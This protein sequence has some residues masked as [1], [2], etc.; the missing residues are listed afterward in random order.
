M[1]G[2]GAGRERSGPL[3]DRFVAAAILLVLAGMLWLVFVHNVN[4]DEFYYLQQVHEH[5]NG[6]L[7]RPLQTFHVHFFQ[8]LTRLPF[9]EMGQ[10]IAVR[11]VMLALFAGT[12]ALIW[13]T[14]RAMVEARFAAIGALCFLGAG[15]AVGHGASF[16]ADPIVAF[17]LMVSLCILFALRLTPLR[18]ALAGLAGAL[19][20]MVSI[21]AVLFAPAFL[22]PVLWRRDEPGALVRVG[23]AGVSAAAFTVVLYLWHKAQLG[24]AGVAQTVEIAG[25]AWSRAILSGPL[26]PRGNEVLL[27]AL[28]SVGPVA[29]I[30]AAFAVRGRP[31]RQ[32]VTLLLLVLPFASVLFYR[33]AFPY[34]FPFIV[35]PLMVAAA[36]GARALGRRPAM[37]ARVL[38]LVAASAVLQ[39]GLSVREGNAVQYRLI[40]AVHK[41]FPEPVAY[42]D[43]NGMI[44]QFPKVGFFMSSWGIANYRRDGLPIFEDILREH[45]PP[46]LIANAP[47][48]DNALTGNGD[49]ASCCGLFLEDREVLRDNYL[50]HSGAVWL[51]GRVLEL[52]SSPRD[53]G[54]LIEGPYRIEAEGTVTINGILH[55]SGEVAQIRQGLNV[56][57]AEQ[58]TALRLLWATERDA[59]ELRALEGPIYYGF[60][61]L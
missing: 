11:L 2:H 43:R 37:L 48:L 24:D 42:I 56:M 25:S 46:L 52:D 47:A 14:A 38:F 21:K 27:W 59:G 33:N 54:F 35:P 45:R 31:L 40:A 3:L 32:T 5:A 36:V 22:A 15:F 29:F 26:L 58:G 60:W 30:L 23:L 1:A 9:D 34:F 4:W 50:H 61:R 41:L 8:W 13:R 18:L 10:V 44:S 20:F 12:A 17:L 49:D 55:A 39:F 6:T 19:A 28:L 7:A 57:S 53:V 16:R 51:A